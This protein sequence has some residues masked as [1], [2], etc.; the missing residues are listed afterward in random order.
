MSAGWVA[1]LATA[2]APAA[3]PDDTAGIEAPATA[4]WM[5]DTFGDGQ[6]VPLGRVLLPGA[7]NSTSYACDAA[8][9]LSPDA[10]EAV[11]ALWGPEDATGNDANRQRVV[12]WARTQD[13]PLGVQLDDG[14][15]FLELN[16]TAK[17]GVITTWH[18]VYGVPL[19]D[20]LDDVV[21]WSV[22]WPDEVVVLTFGLTL[23]SADWPL[24][25]DALTA[26]RA[27]GRSLCQ[28]LY[29]GPEDAAV[30]TLAD[31]RASG[32]P[33]IWSPDGDLRAYLETRGDCLLSHG[34]MD[35][36]WSIT[37]TPEG[38]EAALAASVDTRTPGN[39]LV[40][41]FVF[42]LDG[43]ASVFEQAEYIS[44]YA[45]VEEV[46]EALGFSGDFPGRLI[47]TYDSQG[48]MNVFAGAYYPDTNLVDS[49]IAANKARWGS[50]P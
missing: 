20:V 45:G 33:L 39:L 15:R 37:V 21:A 31:I 4:H 35:R 18:S 48:N 6:D 26:P 13:R 7:F 24:L 41:D 44:T 8:N 34:T 3:E 49:A 28:L 12:D 22:A 40:N 38:V 9:G 50:A 27:E 19:D 1:A 17:D 46:S 30:A 14:I 42:S 11:I 29:N 36:T 2:C 16:V 10:P 32:R 25:A 43:S 5:A 23:D 47:D